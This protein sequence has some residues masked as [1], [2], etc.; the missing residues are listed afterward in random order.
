MDNG[1]EILCEFRFWAVFDV[2]IFTVDDDI[3][4][5]E[6]EQPFEVIPS[7]PTESVSV[8]NHNFFDQSSVAFFQKPY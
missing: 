7:D 5:V 4:S 6:L 3:N 2:F 1:H 8:G